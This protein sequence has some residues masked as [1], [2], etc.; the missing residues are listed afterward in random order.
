[1]IEFKSEESVYCP[2]CGLRQT[3]HV[4]KYYS[5]M[6]TLKMVSLVC[7]QCGE[8]ADIYP[9]SDYIPQNMKSQN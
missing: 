9:V 2:F 5:G 1:M 6:R 8:G 3:P 4:F 7:R